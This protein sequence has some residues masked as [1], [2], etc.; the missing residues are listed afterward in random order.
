MPS[1]IA[2]RTQ[3]IA[4]SFSTWEPWVIQ[5]PYAISLTSRPLWPRCRCFM[6]GL[7]FERRHVDREAVLHIGLDQP[8]VGFIDLLDRD[9]LDVGGDI[10]LAAKVEHP[11]RLRQAA[12]GRA[13]EA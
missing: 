12:D 4:A 3:A 7:R 8:L 11:L 10:V 6:R 5:L 1:S 13:G 9:H 2:A